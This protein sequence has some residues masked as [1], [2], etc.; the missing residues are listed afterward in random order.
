VQQL[1]AEL[2]LQLPDLLGQR[3]LRHVE[4]LGGTAEVPFLGH[5]HE[6]PEM[7]QI[8]ISLISIGS[9]MRTSEYRGPGLAS[10]T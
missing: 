8:H 9:D 1:D 10:L 7:T 2:G 4:P 3:G 6:V 5:R